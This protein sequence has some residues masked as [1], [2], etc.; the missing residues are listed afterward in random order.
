LIKDLNMLKTSLFS[1]KKNTH[2]NLEKSSTITKP[3]L[4]LPMPIAS[5][6]Y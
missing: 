3:H 1:F 5:I 2:V 4:F 6:V